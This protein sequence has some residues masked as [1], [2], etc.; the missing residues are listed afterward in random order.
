M[1][2]HVLVT[3]TGSVST[4]TARALLRRGIR[5][6]LWAHAESASQL[7][8]KAR[9]LEQDGV[10]GATLR[11]GDL[12]D[13]RPLASVDA[14]DVTHVLHAAAVT[15]FDVDRATAEV[16]NVRGTR[17]VLAAAARMPRL[18]HVVLAS[19]VH[20]AGL[21]RGDIAEEALASPPGFANEY[22]RS[23][24]L[25]EECV[26]ATDLPASVARLGTLVVRDS[27]GGAV[28][29]NAVHL[30]LRMLRAGLLAL[31]PGDP[32]TRLPLIS[33]RFTGEALATLLLAGEAGATWHV[34]PEAD[35]CP[36]L[37]RCVSVARDQ[38]A[39]SAA[40]AARRG[41]APPF[42]DLATFEL[43]RG[44][45]QGLAADVV[46]RALDAIAPFAAQLHAPKRFQTTR[47]RAALGALAPEDPVVL[48]RLACDALRSSR[49]LTGV[50][51]C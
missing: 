14:S 47:T 13:E 18:A 6:T 17:R 38:F 7:A 49:Q 30:S 23:K 36:T 40:E 28:T 16:L 34:V 11:G 37:E 10:A 1:N 51:S 19:S 44:G 33:A 2:A 43:L 46:T 8:T 35:D 31:V 20:A 45:A 22:E 3:G 39:G 12:R 24:R 50:S 5:V 9:A 4:A 26:R 48:L 42:V 32:A 27:D 25:A 41:P 29:E 15:R 21:S